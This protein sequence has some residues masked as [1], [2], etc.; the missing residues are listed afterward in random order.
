M[1]CEIFVQLF[2]C[3]ILIWANFIASCT[4]CIA[5]VESVET[6]GVIRLT[7]GR[8]PGRQPSWTCGD[9][10][11]IT[12]RTTRRFSIFQELIDFCGVTVAS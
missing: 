8:P 1:S 7:G 10:L 9:R 11:G 4:L 5:E 3:E 12:E 6:E 2:K